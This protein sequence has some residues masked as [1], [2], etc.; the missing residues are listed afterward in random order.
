VEDFEQVASRVLDDSDGRA[1]EPEENF[2][3]ADQDHFAAAS[4]FAPGGLDE[5]RVPRPPPDPRAP[6]TISAVRE[7]DMHKEWGGMIDVLEHEAY[8]DR[9][10]EAMTDGF[11]FDFTVAPHDS[12][13]D[14]DPFL[15][16][17]LT[18]DEL[19]FDKDYEPRPHVPDRVKGHLF[20]LYSERKWSIRQLANRFGMRPERVSM[21]INMKKTQPA[22]E[23]AGCAD[24]EVD[25]LMTE[26]YATRSH[27]RVGGGDGPDAAR[28]TTADSLPVPQAKDR[29]DPAE[30]FDMGVHVALLRDDQM[31]DDVVP[32]LPMRGNIV[33][34]KH[35]PPRVATPGKEERGVKSKFATVDISGRP[36]AGKRCVVRDWD[37][38]IRPSTRREDL[39][40]THVS[41]HWTARPEA[42]GADDL[43]FAAEKMDEVQWTD[44]EAAAAGAG[45][46]KSIS[47][48]RA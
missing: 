6:R 31:P 42:T 37:G 15:N 1:E 36:N 45:A 18:E 9:V 21:I 40:R 25:G 47:L 24:P 33:R 2:S 11:F 32:R 17:Y 14:E 43:P 30:D 19:W 12:D 28:G 4:M 13:H 39:Y 22:L 38:S 20:Y 35:M 46:A 27:R 8:C 23:E 16:G 3:D 26:M 5:M 41:R 44:S 34:L 29:I 7:D 48:E 10:R